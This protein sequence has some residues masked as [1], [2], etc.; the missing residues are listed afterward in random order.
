MAA[1]SL[2]SCFKDEAPNAE[3]DI[4]KAW[5]QLGEDEWQNMFFNISDTT[6]KVLYSDR[7][8]YFTVRPEARLDS[9]CPQ[10]EITEGATISQANGS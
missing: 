7:N 9:I 1:L 6:K 4:T 5:V 8:I 3:C 10:F 2:T